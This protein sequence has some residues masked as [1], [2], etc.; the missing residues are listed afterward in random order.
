MIG[1]RVSMISNLISDLK[2]LARVWVRVKG[3]DG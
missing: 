1:L 2:V 3:L